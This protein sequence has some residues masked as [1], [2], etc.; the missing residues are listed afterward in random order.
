MDLMLTFP[1]VA[2]QSYIYD[3]IGGGK[4][5]FLILDMWNLW[6]SNLNLC[7]LL[8]VIDDFRLLEANSET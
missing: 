2:S 6:I 7:I 4:K 1:G 3:L 8:K 5:L